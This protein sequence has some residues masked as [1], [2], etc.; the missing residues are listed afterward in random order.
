M[1]DGGDSGLQ[2]VT[3]DFYR[4]MVMKQDETIVDLMAQQKELQKTLKIVERKLGFLCI[5]FHALT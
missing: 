1:V 3:F 4:K 2:L 5:Q